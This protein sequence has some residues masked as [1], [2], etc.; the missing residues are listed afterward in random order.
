ML[1]VSFYAYSHNYYYWYQ[2]KQIPLSLG[3]HFYIIYDAKEIKGV[4]SLQVIDGGYLSLSKEAQ[5]KWGIV[6][7]Q[8]A[9]NVKDVLYQMPSFASSD[10]TQDMF[11]THR[12]YV[13]LKQPDD[14]ILLNNL[15][16][17]YQ[18]EI[19]QEGDFP[20]WYIIRCGLNS[21]QNALSLANIFYES[22]L[23]DVAE[24]EFINA[25]HVDCVNDP[26]FSQQWNLKNTGQWLESYS[27][28]DINYCDAHAITSGNASTIIGVYDLG[29]DLT[30]PDINLYSFSYDVNSQSSPSN[31]YFSSDGY[32]FH[33]TACA[34][35][36]GAK[37][38]N[39]IGIAG[40]APN[41]PIMS[42][43]FHNT[44]PQNIG[45][46]FKVAADHD[47]SVISNSWRYDAPSDY[48]NEG[49]SYAL[50]HGR[51][52]KGCVVVFSAGNENR[53]SINYPA[54]SNDSIIVVGAMSPCGQRCN[55]YS[56]DGYNWGSNYGTKLD[57]MA[58]GVLIRTTDIVG[59]GGD[60]SSDY[61]NDFMGTSA[62]CPHVAAVA[63]LILS[64]N[65]FLTQKEVV[66]IIE[67][68]AQK[69]G[70][71]FNP[72]PNRPNGTWSSGFGYG[73]VD[74]YAAVLEA[75]N[76]LPKIQG[77]DYVCDTAKYYLIHPFSAGLTVQWNVINELNANPL[78]TIVGPSNQ[79]TV[80]ITYTNLAGSRD[81]MD[82][83]PIFDDRSYV[84]VS[85][86]QEY[87]PPVTYSRDLNYTYSIK[88]NISASNTATIWHPT[89]Q[90][91]FTIT[92]CP[93]VPDSALKWTVKRI[94][95]HT[96]HNFT[97]VVQTNYFYGRTL[98]YTAP[99]SGLLTQRDSMFIYATNLA[100]DCG[101]IE[102][103]TLLFIITNQHHLLVSP[104]D[105]GLLNVM[106]TEGMDGTQ[107]VPAILNEGSE[108]VLELTNSIYGNKRTKQVQ[109]ANEQ[110]NIEGLLP[111]VYVLLLKENGE[112]IAQEKVLIQ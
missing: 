43:S 49:I 88:P 26:M 102:S 24:P 73:L 33:G 92:N 20:L 109:S 90:R 105:I 108:Y 64:V 56:C 40:I 23:F 77:P 81:V 2:G 8:T 11:V 78:F 52:G 36:I 35:I 39:S 80:V 37:T 51:N 107:Y 86:T 70:M 93:L 99:S 89:T 95:A 32:N 3:N 41:C 87:N 106:I 45:N 111:G 47:C 31:I 15:V 48:I 29:V 21:Q 38:D 71:D 98:S 4:D 74:A 57:V 34:G 112:V 27:G 19:E 44:T 100:G 101:S 97:P 7:Q 53:D 76:R 91:T 66:D 17:Q 110:V 10:P 22:G 1:S 65:P 96:F 42:I 46:G 63:G 14:I 6:S 55:P 58:P 62:A 94:V 61:I 103:D 68:T 30:H 84:T 79:D 75:Q 28:I 18:A 5:I 83:R 16:E 50:S 9:A 104:G 59:V 12:F 60:N 85:L 13:K 82:N 25:I 54:N 72:T 69:V 67:S